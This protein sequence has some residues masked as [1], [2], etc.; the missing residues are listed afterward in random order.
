MREL[1]LR[2]SA[3]YACN[4]RIKAALLNLILKGVTNQGVLTVYQKVRPDKLF[5]TI[6]KY[7][8]IDVDF[9]KP[10]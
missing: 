10:I 5:K 6:W 1:F 4:K 9:Y 2:N 8:I 3:K 7:S